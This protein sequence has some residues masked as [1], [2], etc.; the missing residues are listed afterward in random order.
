MRDQRTLHSLI[1]VFISVV[2]LFVYCVNGEDPY[3]FYTWK[4]TYGNIYPMGVK[5][6]G[7]LINGQ[8]P[9][10]QI[11]CVT[12]DNLIISVYNYLTEPF[13]I[14]WNGLQHRRNSWQDGTYGT[15]CPIP[16]GKNFTYMLQAKDQIGSYFYFPSLGLHK[17]A[18]GFGGIKIF[19]RPRIPV[20]FPPPAGDHTVLAGD[21]YKRSHRVHVIPVFG[22]DDRVLRAPLVRVF[23]LSRN[24]NW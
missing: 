9:G 11:N 2:L 17:A 6:Q 24:F 3:R 14:S 4:I 8:F 18:G 16:P 15:N 1:S 13:L 22:Y 10:P 23:I 19:S 20:P 12:N 21:W 5:Q 7:I